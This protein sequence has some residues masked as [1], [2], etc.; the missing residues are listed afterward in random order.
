M[1]AIV[2]AVAMA[3]LVADQNIAM[4][5]GSAK[6]PVG[7]QNV[8][9]SWVH[10]DLMVFGVDE[11]GLYQARLDQSRPSRLVASLT[12]FNRGLAI[13][14]DGR[15]LVY[16]TSSNDYGD[17]RVRHIFDRSTSKDRIIPDL[18][19]DDNLERYEFLGF[20]PDSKR[21]AWQDNG[22]IESSTNDGSRPLLLIFS[23]D[24]LDLHRFSYPVPTTPKSAT[25]SCFTSQWS[26]DGKAIYSNYQLGGNSCEVP[27]TGK[28]ELA[29]FKTDVE[30]GKQKSVTGEYAY[31]V[32]Q[33][34]FFRVSY[35]DDGKALHLD[36]TCL[37]GRNCGFNYDDKLASGTSRAWFHHVQNPSGVM[38]GAEELFVQV[39]GTLPRK[40]ESGWSSSCSGTDIEIVGW[41]EK[42][43]YL[44]YKL[45]GNTYIYGVDEG[46]KSLLPQ[47]S[48]DYNWLPMDMGGGPHNM[49][50][51]NNSILVSR[52]SD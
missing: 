45:K 12:K 29:Y 44:V 5:C 33:K 35:I 37:H 24:T 17:D 13:S 22:P 19:R 46:R 7:V 41:V 51:G 28:F 34:Y 43:K 31:G 8:D 30:S 4:A 50:G 49:G 48:G 26:P 14:P 36:Y 21:V 15:Y 40:I 3:V 9:L 11:Q 32:P 42:G 1:K 25:S 18:S 38:D 39:T 20:S 27:A 2:L 10:S 52:L 23:A 16:S 47:L 6:Q